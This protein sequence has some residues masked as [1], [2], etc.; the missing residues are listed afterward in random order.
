MSKHDEPVVHALGVPSLALVSD[1]KS[2]FDITMENTEDFV[3]PPE[4]L[5]EA[6]VHDTMPPSPL[7]MDELAT[8]PTPVCPP[9]HLL[10]KPYTFIDEDE[11][12]QV[13]FT[14]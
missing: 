2:P 13:P 3:P 4:L 9:L 8:D 10:E 1:I 11:T 14:D 12:P 5:T 6:S 7:N